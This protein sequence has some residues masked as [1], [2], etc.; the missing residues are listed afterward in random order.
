MTTVHVEQLDVVQGA[1]F[2]FEF[3]WQLSVTVDDVTTV[4][5]VPIGHMTAA[6]Q[7]RKS[8]KSPVLLEATTENGLIILGEGTAPEDPE[9]GRIQFRWPGDET[10]K[11]DVA[12]SVYDFELYD[13]TET[14][15]RTYQL[16]RGPVITILNVTREEP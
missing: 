14:P 4:T 15:L 5:A 13:A 3:R 2:D 16:I 11:I 6:L 12:K 8:L 10:M 1:T 9:T 7:V